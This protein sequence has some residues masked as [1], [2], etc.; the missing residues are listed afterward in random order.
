MGANLHRVAAIS[1]ARAFGSGQHQVGAMNALA[2]LI[3]RPANSLEAFKARCWAKALLVSEGLMDFY[4]AVDGLQNAAV[5]FRLAERVGQ[6]EVQRIMAEAFGEE[7]P[8]LQSGV[9]DIIRRWELADPRDA[10]CHNGKPPPSDDFRNSNIARAPEPKPRPYKTPSSTV[11]AF[12]FLAS[13]GDIARLDA[14]LAAHKQDAPFL[15]KLLEGK[16][17]A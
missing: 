1:A 13:Q 2:L 16:K 8:E 10:W 6:D 5:A 7:L 9:D 12:K 15:L 11:A 4:E 17:N 14:W 3:N